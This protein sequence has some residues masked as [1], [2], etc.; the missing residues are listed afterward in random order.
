MNEKLSLL[1][2]LIILAQ[3]DN[4]VNNQEYNFIL[5]IAKMLLVSQ[6]ELDSLFEKQIEYSPPKSEFERIVQFYRL[7]LLANVDLHLADE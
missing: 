1:K 2:Q 6:E 5:R 4:K 7:V 3:A